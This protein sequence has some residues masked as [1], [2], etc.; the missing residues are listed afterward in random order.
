MTPATLLA[1]LYRRGSVI[2]VRGGRLGVKAPDGVLTPGARSAMIAHK[3]AL[4][5][6]VPQAERYRRLLVDA[7]NRLV[8]PSG[9]SDDQCAAFLDR[10]AR[11]VDDL[12]PALASAIYTATALEWRTRTGVCPWCDDEGVCHEPKPRDP[13]ES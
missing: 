11:Y 5:Q 12:G 10:Q 7:L 2:R 4:L 13:A 3:P 9:P 6:L 8:V 1:E